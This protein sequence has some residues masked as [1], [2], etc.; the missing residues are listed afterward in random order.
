MRRFFIIFSWNKLCYHI[1]T[2][3]LEAI[4]KKFLIFFVPFLYVLFFVGCE[5]ESLGKSSD[6]F[7]FGRLFDDAVEGVEYESAGTRG[8]TSSDGTFKYK[9]NTIVTFTVGGVTVG[10]MPTGLIKSDKIVF[11]PDLAQTDRNDTNNSQ[12]VNTARFL[13]SLDADGNPSNGITIPASVRASLAGSTL[14]LTSDLTTEG[15]LNTAVTTAGKTLIDEDK[16]IAHIEYVLQ[17]ELGLDVDTVPPAPPERASNSALVTNSDTTNVTIIG[18]PTSKIFINNVQSSQTIGSDG[19]QSVA[20]DTSG[21][22]GTKNFTLF[23]QDDKDKNST[24]LSLGVLKDSIAP[25]FTS[26]ATVSVNENQTG[27]LDVDATDANSLTYSISGTDASALSINASTG[28]LTF[29][30]APDFET[31]SSYSLTVTASDGVNNATQNIV[32]TILDQS[33]VVPILANSSGSVAENSATGTSVGTVSISSTGDSAISAIT[34]SGT[35]N[36]NF[37]VAT[38]GAITV[39]A[40]AVLDFETTSTYNLQAIATNSSGDSQ[41]VDV[42]ISITN[43]SDVVPVLAD[44]SGSIAENSSANSTVGTITISNSGDSAISAITLSG[45]NNSHFS[46][47]TDG[48][49]RV[50]SG[51]ALDFETYNTYT[52]TAVATNS[53]GNSVAKNVT[54]TLTN[55]NDVVPVLNTFSGSVDEN[56]LQGTSVGS[57]TIANSGDSAISAITLSGT[58]NENFSVATNGAITV[59]N[60]ANLDFETKSTYTLSAVATNS[61]GNSASVSVAI[62]LNDVN[63]AIPTLD[64]FNGSVD[65]NVT[66]GTQVGTITIINSGDS[67]ISA[68]DLNGT[69]ATDFSVATNGVITTAQ[70]LDFENQ[71]SYT[72]SAKATNN[73]G[74]SNYVNVTITIN[75]I[76]EEAPVFTTSATPSVAENST[77]VID[78]N[79]T[80]SSVVTFSIAGGI[81][82]AKFSINSSSGLLSFQ[83]APDFENATDNGTD[84]IYDVIVTATDNLG[85]ESNQSLNVTVTNVDDVVPILLNLNTDVDENATTNNVVG[86][87]PIFLSGDS[88]ITTITLSGTGNTNFDVNTSGVITVSASAVLD[89]ETTTIYN[90]NAVATNNA[91]DSGQVNVNIAINDINDTP[92]TLSP[93][94]TTLDENVTVGTQVGTIT[95]NDSGDSAISAMD[96]NGTGATDF[97]VATDGVITTAQTL[98]FE[99]QNSY[100]LSAKATNT[101]GDSPYVSVTITLN[102]IDEEAP[103]FTTSATPSVRENNTS[104]IDINVTDSS[105]VTFSIV[106][107]DDSAKFAINTNSGLLTFQ[108][109]PNFESPTDVGGNNVYEVVVNALDSVG[110]E[111]NQSLSVTVTNVADIVPT[112]LNFQGSV[113][114]NA[115]TGT[116][117]GTISA[118][119]SGDSAISSFTLTGTGNENF[120]VSSGGVITVSASASLDFETQPLYNLNAIATND[121]G[122]SNQVTVDI[123]ITDVVE[124]V[125]TTEL[126]IASAVYDDNG[127]ATASDDV[128]T[129]YFNKAINALDLSPTDP[130]VDYNITGT[131]SIGTNSVSVYESNQYFRHTIMLDGTSTA[132]IPNTTTIAIAHNQIRDENN[133]SYPQDYNITTVTPIKPV[134]KTARVTSFPDNSATDRDDG[135]YQSGHT[136]RYTRNDTD[137]IV[138]DH[139]TGLIWQDT[140]AVATQTYTH[141]DANTSCN[142]LIIGA[143]NDWRMPTLEEL[144]TIVH[145]GRF[146]PAIYP[147]FNNTA[148][149]GIYWSSDGFAK[150]A[151]YSLVVN[152]A[153]GNN[154]FKQDGSEGGY[155]SESHYVRCVKDE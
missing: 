128:L 8:T 154:N 50:A 17:K 42:T 35:G 144:M 130:G 124:P 134:V 121:A 126:Y 32:I 29:N 28:V 129:L 69:G 105:T 123:N 57:I 155:P 80:D 44:F 24:T 99:N 49:I 94:S 104:V 91:G 15:N 31:K 113:E 103:V 25:V 3:F 108:S 14:D 149:T 75:D 111:A 89:F 45:T 60:G 83:S 133:N 9:R 138:T 64:H 30:S 5:A 18:E 116:Q 114:E 76:D 150:S 19:T 146:N 46:V 110:N 93:F 56:S 22:D 81:D 47:A 67:A 38:N 51:A 1:I 54:I 119:D 106:G 36:G 68:I 90:L 16:A 87:I 21:A 86:T 125:S 147:I 27:A 39:K 117:V 78:I 107:G 131:G 102:N 6:S 142:D 98:D 137:N 10:Q 140:T 120:D 23:L 34:L 11:L 7:L 153:N 33:D 12:V 88:A 62:T 61:A 127:T 2:V 96:L 135:Y 40:G 115:T 20:L 48:T 52:L 84:N 141:V 92:P 4:L 145:K 148:S 66:V 37:E 101:A 63:D 70:T 55:V 132:F 74:D 71:N 143:H 97:S 53:A 43:V 59:A 85:Y 139:I 13:Q 122:N 73:A 95:I 100:T 109:A 26:S 58:G 152:F 77:S 151:I 79:V 82:S 41:A 72:L 118:F 112:I 136:R 65:E